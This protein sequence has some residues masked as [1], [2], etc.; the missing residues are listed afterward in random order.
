MARRAGK[1]TVATVGRP[2]GVI[3]VPDAEA[4]MEAAG[5]TEDPGATILEISKV[6]GMNKDATRKHIIRL[7]ETGECTTGFSRR[8]CCD[9][10][11]MRVP[12]YQLTK[13]L[14][15]KRKKKS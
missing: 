6:F 1:P 7:V 9:G 10:R 4:W 2:Q 8:Q 12:V 3:N 15:S 13:K 5:I 11:L 14:S